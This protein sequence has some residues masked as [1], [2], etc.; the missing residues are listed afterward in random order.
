MGSAARPARGPGAEQFVGL[1]P[2]AGVPNGLQSMTGWLA[3]VTGLLG[4]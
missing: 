2:L 4:A 1:N 3:P